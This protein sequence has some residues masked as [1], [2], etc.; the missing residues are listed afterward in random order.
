MNGIVLFICNTL[1]LFCLVQICEEIRNTGNWREKPSLLIKLSSSD[2]GNALSVFHFHCNLRNVH[3][4]AG[5]QFSYSAFMF[6][7]IH[8]ELRTLKT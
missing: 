8:A 4:K 5:N 6:C 1:L 7:G 2:G 3:S